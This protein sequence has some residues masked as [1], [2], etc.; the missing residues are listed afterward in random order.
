MIY[1]F[2]KLANFFYP[3]LNLRLVQVIFHFGMSFE[4]FVFLKLSLASPPA[5]I[6]ETGRGDNGQPCVILEVWLIC[7]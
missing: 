3:T 6:K 7:L 2:T 4:I 1:I 5:K